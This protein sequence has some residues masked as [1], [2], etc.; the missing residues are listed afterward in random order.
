MWCLRSVGEIWRAFRL[1]HRPVHV[2]ADPLHVLADPPGYMAT[3]AEAGRDVFKGVA[4]RLEGVAA[5]LGLRS[6]GLWQAR[7]TAAHLPERPAGPIE[8]ER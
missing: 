3:P 1:P 5:G 2:R 7:I 4:V 6:S 8:P